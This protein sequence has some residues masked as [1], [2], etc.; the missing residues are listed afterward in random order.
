MAS[1]VTVPNSF[2]NGTTADALDVNENFSAITNW[3]NANAVHLDGSKA[4][5][6]IPSGPSV[7]PSSANQLA[8]KAYVDA[9]VA[10]VNLTVGGDLSGT[11]SNAQ[12][13]AN[14][15]GTTEINASAVTTAK[16]ADAAV[17]EAKLA[18][19]V[20]GGGLTGGA[21]TALAV[22]VDGSTLEINTDT[23]RVKDAGITN[24]KMATAAFTNIKSIQS[25]D[26]CG[27][28]TAFGAQTVA[29]SSSWT[30]VDLTFE[31]YDPSNMHSTTTNTQR[32]TAPV[33]GM[34]FFNAHVRFTA[35]GGAAVLGNRGLRLAH[36][37]SGGTLTSIVGLNQHYVG[38]TT[39]PHAVNVA[40]G[41]YLAAGEYVD[42]QVFQNSGS[43]L[44]L[45]WD[46]DGIASFSWHCVKVA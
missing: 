38:N 44:D 10:A 11:T 31:I 36:Y 40:G 12:I 7:D 16:I 18:A 17:T 45:L 29:S 27:R 3:V 4:F 37:T 5:T 33:A 39:S 19:S 26:Y 24:A 6:A 8:R 15:V 20:A 30:N 28:A 14:A 34:Y 41:T 35:T 25:S 9:Q 22:N 42:L 46:G 23:V 43:S 21:G 2:S 13:V 32:V 1:N